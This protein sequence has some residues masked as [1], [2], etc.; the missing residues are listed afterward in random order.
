MSAQPLDGPV[1]SQAAVYRRL[2]QNGRFGSQSRRGSPIQG[3]GTSTLRGQ[4]YHRAVLRGPAMPRCIFAAA[5]IAKNAVDDCL[6]ETPVAK[7]LG[8]TPST[9]IAR[10]FAPRN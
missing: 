3:S 7:Q 4:P 5:A 10:Y 1:C 6:L 8:Q 2:D 9:S